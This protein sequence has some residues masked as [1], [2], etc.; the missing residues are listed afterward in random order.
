MC[1]AL[2]LG[3]KKSRRNN[4]SSH[5]ENNSPSQARWYT[6]IIPALRRQK[7]DD[8]KFEAGLG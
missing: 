8:H 1:Q 3:G 7:Q 2:V 4:G 5:H 6:A